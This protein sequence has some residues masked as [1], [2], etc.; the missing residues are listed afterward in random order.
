MPSRIKE[1]GERMSVLRPG[2]RHLKRDCWFG[3]RAAFER[4]LAAFDDTVHMVDTAEAAPPADGA[5]LQQRSKTVRRGPWPELIQDVDLG[6]ITEFAV[7][8]RE[9]CSGPGT[10]W[11]EFS[12]RHGVILKASPD[13]TTRVA[14]VS[15]SLAT[16]LEPGVPKHA[17]LRSE[18]LGGIVAIFLGVLFELAWLGLTG[19]FGGPTLPD[20]VAFP[21]GILVGLVLVYLVDRA[22]PRF[23]VIDPLLD[24]RTT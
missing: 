10:L 18:L 8:E 7:T 24:S 23:H 19:R 14:E 21:V 17:W 6:T 15:V 16:A 1:T 4:V 11:L 12:A 9:S 13:V 5:Y 22:W 3:D 2:R 20:F